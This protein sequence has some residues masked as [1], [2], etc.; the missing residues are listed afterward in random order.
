MPTGAGLISKK[1]GPFFR[2]NPRQTWRRNIRNLMGR[3]AQIGAQDVAE[4]LRAG[5]ADR[6]PLRGI[7]PSRVA[8]WVHGRT[9]SRAGRQWQ[10]TAVVSIDTRGLSR[11][12]ARQVMA[13]ASLLESR[14][15]PFRR[16]TSRL[17]R[18]R[19]MLEDGLLE[20][21]A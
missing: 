20:G 10:V 12:Q 7:E 1:S 19:R 18:V 4:G 9:I 3:V 16:T 6:Q 21:L 11:R 8:D 13:A 15:H 5:Q 14:Q 17:R 2:G